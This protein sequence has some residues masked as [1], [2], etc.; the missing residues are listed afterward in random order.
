MGSGLLNE[1]IQK[2]L[3]EHDGVCTAMVIKLLGKE[4]RFLFRELYQKY[5]HASLEQLDD[6]DLFCCYLSMCDMP[7]REKTFYQSYNKQLQPYIPEIYGM[8]DR[9]QDC[10]LLMEDLSYC[11]HMD[12]VQ[13]PE[14]WG[15]KEINLAIE[16]LAFFHNLDLCKGDWQFKKT[17]HLDD[18]D[19]IARFLESLEKSMMT[20]S[21]IGRI[22]EVETA[23]FEFIYHLE[24]Y[25]E[26]L[27]RYGRRMIHHDFNIRNICID[28]KNWQLK[29]YDWEFI[30]DRNPLMDL[31]DLFVSLSTEILTPANL[32]EWLK[33]YVNESVGY[34]GKKEQTEIKAQLY[35]NVL[36]F[37]ATRMNMY[38]LF[39][40]RKK[41]SYMERM[42]RNLFLL[43]NY[44]REGGVGNGIL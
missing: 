33:I 4:P 1:P 42:Y 9:G 13:N 11:T 17:E 37:A 35:I 39:Y 16:T 22:A 3:V 41:D 14:C 10:L 21:G 2:C 23:A 36:K 20:Y 24:Q 25:E 5:G 8:I 32:D 15:R 28:E 18:Y 34:G 7:Q 30:D 19:G 27:S 29:V 44:S 6:F 12:M 31:V 38:L 26:R 40:A 43:L